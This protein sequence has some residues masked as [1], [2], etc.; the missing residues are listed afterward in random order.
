[1]R[2]GRVAIA[3]VAVALLGLVD[4]GGALACSCLRSTPAESLA[5]SDAAIV[6]R[7]LAVEPRGSGQAVYRYKVMRVFRGAKAIER[8]S[9]LGVHGT[10]GGAACGLP[11]RTGARLGLFLYRDRNRWS[12]NLC[13]VV[14]PRLLREAAQG[15]RPGAGSSAADPSCAV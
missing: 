14:S 2:G 8:G 9:T 3:V 11:E 13:G 6:G 15:S 12:G 4:A 10:R 1:M 7:L 5:R